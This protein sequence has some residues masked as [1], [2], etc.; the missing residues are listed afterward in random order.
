LVA[1][2]GPKEMEEMDVLGMDDK[3]F[4]ET[5]RRKLAGM[6]EKNGARQ[7]VVPLSK[8]EKYIKEGWE[9]HA[10]LPNGKAII[11]L[12]PNLVPGAE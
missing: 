2:F 12:P 8:I 7:K 9:F 6:M 4:Q 5:I 3:E 11:K 1:G 10:A